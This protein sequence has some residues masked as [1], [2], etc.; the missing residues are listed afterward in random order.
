MV[1]VSQNSLS[2]CSPDIVYVKQDG[3]HYILVGICGEKELFLGMFEDRHTVKL[4]IQRI[5]A[6]IQQGVKVYC[7]G[8]DECQSVQDTA[9]AK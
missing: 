3:D 4:E 9:N 2:M 8:E 6:A 5:A 1:I 7:V